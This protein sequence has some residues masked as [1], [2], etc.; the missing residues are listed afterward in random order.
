MK[1]D[2]F[3]IIKSN[4]KGESNKRVSSLQQIRTR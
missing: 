3:D 4:A 1:N 2:K